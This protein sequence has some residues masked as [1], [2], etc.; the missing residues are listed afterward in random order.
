MPQYDETAFGWEALYH[1]QIQYWGPLFGNQ[2]FQNYNVNFDSDLGGEI[3][4]D[5]KRNIWKS[6]FLGISGGYRF[7]RINEFICGW[8]DGGAP[9]VTG[10]VMEQNRD[11]GGYKVSGLVEWK[12]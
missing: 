2:M 3:G 11:F 7:L 4:F 8:N 1:R 9:G 12:F 6:L 10:W 5:F